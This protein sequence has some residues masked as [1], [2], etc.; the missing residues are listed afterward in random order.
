M[1]SIGPNP[2]HSKEVMVFC[3]G[4]FYNN[5]VKNKTPSSRKTQQDPSP[6][7]WNGC[8]ALIYLKDGPFT[9][10]LE[11]L[12]LH[13]SKRILW[14]GYLDQIYVDSLVGPPPK[15]LSEFLWKTTVCVLSPITRSKKWLYISASFC[16][17]AFCYDVTYFARIINLNFKSAVLNWCYQR[18][19]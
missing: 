6:T 15:K 7:S 5:E 2:L 3:R 10:I 11:N 1:V 18:F 9:A 14:F 13:Q 16:C 17:A 19:Y 8:N 4:N 12:N